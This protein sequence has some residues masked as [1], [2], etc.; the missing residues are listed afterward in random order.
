MGGTNFAESLNYFVPP[1][2]FNFKRLMDT[3]SSSSIRFQCIL[4]DDG[5]L[6]EDS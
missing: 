5:V 6:F 2:Y 4:H 3:I 1:L